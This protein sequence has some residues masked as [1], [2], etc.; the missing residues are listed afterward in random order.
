M[1]DLARWIHASA[2]QYVKAVATTMTLPCLIEGVEER[3]KAFNE[4]DDRLE[5][6]MNGP[7]WTLH[8]KMTEVR[9]SVNVL[10]TSNFGNSNKNGFVLQ[11]A[12]GKLQHALSLPIPLYRIGLPTDN[13]L[14]FGC[15]ISKRDIKAFQFGQLD[16][17]HRTRQGLVLA[18][19]YYHFDT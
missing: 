1:E 16:A 5:F 15:L 14:Q 9:V 6:R 3:T 12:L 11:T 18:P 7:Y 19:Y 8:H 13:R 4:A 2:A 17:S 10:V